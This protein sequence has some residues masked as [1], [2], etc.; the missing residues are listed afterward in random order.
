MEQ[1]KQH[2]GSRPGAG[3]KAEAGEK[4]KPAVY[5]VSTDEAERIKANAEKSGLSVAE[6]VRMRALQSPD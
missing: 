4:R 2:G 6:Y 5:Y 3:R 1:Q